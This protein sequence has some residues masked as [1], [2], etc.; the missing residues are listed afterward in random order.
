MSLPR[1]LLDELLSRYMDGDLSDDE[2]IRVEQI[3]E[4]DS[5]ARSSLEELRLSGSLIRRAV[6]ASGRLD[7][8]FSS[9]VFEA[10]VAQMDEAGIPAEHP[11]RLAA[12]GGVNSRFGSRRR[13]VVGILALAVSVMFAVFVVNRGNGPEGL[14][15]KNGLLQIPANNDTDVVV[16]GSNLEPIDKAEV[17]APS[18]MLAS[19]AAGDSSP[20]AA[21]NSDQPLLPNVPAEAIATNDS[22]RNTS[23]NI[24]GGIL[25]GAALSSDSVVSSGKAPSRIPGGNPVP[26]GMEKLRMLIAY[27]VLVTASGREKN[28][29]GR[30]FRNAGIMQGE[31]RDVDAAMV[32]FLRDG[33][34]IGGPATELVGG[35]EGNAA[36]CELVFLE[37]SG[38]KID[39]AMLDLLGAEEDVSKVGWRVIMDPPVFA[40]IDRMK[41]VEAT[42]VRSVEP[43]QS[44]APSTMASSLSPLGY[45]GSDGGFIVGDQAFQPVGRDSL[46][47]L[48]EMSS[49]GQE[50][51]A[52]ITSQVLMIIRYE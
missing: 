31:Q 46:K 47:T 28:V 2:R 33:G 12:S 20:T 30:V 11:L 45:A 40:A 43:R 1:E 7:S 25:P 52:D 23:S 6:D 37:G 35:E 41:E 13:M 36:R 15:A 32:G 29:V 39:Q 38:L 14:A 8:G 4:A 44:G 26:A 49:F 24:P 50:A 51:G 17:A 21:S 34:V 22:P 16:D 9:R 18:T 42:K 3:L 27:E 5:E 19:D 10:A 48:S